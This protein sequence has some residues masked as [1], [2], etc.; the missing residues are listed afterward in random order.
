MMQ[1]GRPRCARKLSPILLELAIDDIDETSVYDEVVA[2]QRMLD[3]VGWE[4]ERER[5]RRVEYAALSMSEIEMLFEEATSR[6]GRR[7][8]SSVGG[9]PAGYADAM[10]HLRSLRFMREIAEDN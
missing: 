7:P 4:I 8:R 2:E 6:F 1:V 10:T 5:R 9:V 3:Y